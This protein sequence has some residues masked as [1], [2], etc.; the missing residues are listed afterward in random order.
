MSKRGSRGA[1]LWLASTATDCLACESLGF[2]QREE[3]A[4]EGWQGTESPLNMVETL[5]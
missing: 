1:G 4:R 5:T 2:P 3:A